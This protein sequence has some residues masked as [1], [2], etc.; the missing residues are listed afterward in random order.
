MEVWSFQNHQQF[1]LSIFIIC[2]LLCWI[3]GSFKARCPLSQRLSELVGEIFEASSDL[4]REHMDGWWE[5]AASL[6]KCSTLPPTTRWKTFT[7]Y[8]MCISLTR[9]NILLLC[10]SALIPQRLLTGIICWQGHSFAPLSY[11]GRCFFPKMIKGAGPG[12]FE[13]LALPKLARPPFYPVVSLAI[14]CLCFSLP[15]YYSLSSSTLCLALLIISHIFV[16]FVL[17]DSIFWQ[18][19]TS[20]LLRWLKTRHLKVQVIFVWDPLLINIELEVLRELRKKFEDS[21]LHV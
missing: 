18:K 9:G 10:W 7:S 4:Q 5:T 12:A 19:G 11:T 2:W 13:I 8:F 17:W 14:P 15:H 3:W 1:Y 20:E 21:S 6:A 16:N